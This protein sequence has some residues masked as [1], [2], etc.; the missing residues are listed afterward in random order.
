MQGRCI[1]MVIL[2]DLCLGSE[3]PPTPGQCCCDVPFPAV[4]LL[5]AQRDEDGTCCYD[6]KITGKSFIA[7][8]AL[9]WD[10]GPL[11]FSFK[12]AKNGKLI[13]PHTF[14]T[15]IHWFLLFV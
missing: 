4:C 1:P 14:L 6:A 13:T 5:G 2:G 15:F 12:S 11:S 3:S 8:A 7:Q 10:S 9:M